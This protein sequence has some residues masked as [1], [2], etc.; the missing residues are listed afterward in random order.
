MKPHASHTQRHTYIQ[1]D[2][3]SYI[4]QWQ[5]QLTND[6]KKKKLPQRQYKKIIFSSA[7]RCFLCESTQ[8]TLSEIMA[9]KK[10]AEKKTTT[11]VTF[12]A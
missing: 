3:L 6:E 4:N 7:T 1:R 11:D 12:L 5:W 10:A 2:A 8:N 9:R